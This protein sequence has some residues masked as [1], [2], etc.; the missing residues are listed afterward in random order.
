MI[1][2]VCAAILRSD[3]VLLCRRAEG[4]HLAG[5]W[6]FP[7][8][9]VED[10]EHP[11]EALVREIREELSCLVSVGAALPDV[12]HEYPEVAIRLLPFLCVVEDGRPL[13]LEHEEL[14]WFR[15]DRGEPPG[16]AAADREVW[17]RL[18]SRL[19]SASGEA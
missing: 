13:A 17:K 16:L 14:A 12:E 11:R 9:K 4:A 8:G 1:D 7:G 10:G 19:G 15:T 6:E 5:A 3:E 18:V 2:V